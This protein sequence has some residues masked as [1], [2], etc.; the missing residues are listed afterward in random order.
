MG[1][2]VDADAF[3]RVGFLACQR[4]NLDNGVQFF[5]EEGE[6]PLGR[7]D[8]WAWDSNANAVVSNDLIAPTDE[9]TVS[10]R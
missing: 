10:P 1:V 7:A 9:V 4:V 3:E 8:V 2:G 6:P 5:T